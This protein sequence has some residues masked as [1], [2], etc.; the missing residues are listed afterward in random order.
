[1]NGIIRLGGV[2]AVATIVGLGAG[3]A[4]AAPAQTDGAML[5][6]CQDIGNPSSYRITV[7]GAYPMQQPDA[8]GYLIHMNDGNHPGGS[9]PGG[10][11]VQLKADNPGNNSD[12]DI[13]YGFY[14]TTQTTSEGYLK[15]GPSGPST[16]AKWSSPTEFQRGLPAARRRR[17]RRRGLCRRDVPRRWRRRTACCDAGDHTQ[18]RGAGHL[19]RLLPLRHE[20]TTMNNNSW[21][22]K[23]TAT[24][25]ALTAVTTAPA[26]AAPKPSGAT[27]FLC[28]D[29][30]KPG[31]YRV[32][33]RGV[34]PMTQADAEGYLIHIDDNPAKPGHMVYYLQ[35]DDGHGHEGD[36]SIA[37]LTVPHR[38]SDAGGFSGPALVAWNTSVSCRCAPTTSMP[39]AP[40]GTTPT[41]LPAKISTDL[42]RG[43]IHRRR[44]WRKD[45][46]QPADHQ[47]LHRARRLRRCCS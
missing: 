2:A 23:L 15:A 27:L 9:G 46:D 32:T 45:A 37:Y 42:C 20:E 38:H 36:S 44:W 24:V 13:G 33:I 12:Y 30:G 6:I 34:F 4:V 31:S 16:G 29:F 26:V 7:K 1:M 11:R 10:L 47:G 3:T 35:D 40:S 25:L 22:V 17:Q 39:T 43:N 19:R 41:G 8:A 18:F 14:P 21:P 28:P 5:Y